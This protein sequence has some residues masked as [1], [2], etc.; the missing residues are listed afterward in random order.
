MSDLYRFS[1][2]QIISKNQYINV[3]YIDSINVAKAS[4]SYLQK[5]KG[6]IL[7]FASGLCLN[8]TY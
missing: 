4:I 8:I 2:E 7:M 1:N 6:Y 5:T 3:N